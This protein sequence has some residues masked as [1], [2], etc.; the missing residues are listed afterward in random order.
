MLLSADDLQA[1][2]LSLKLAGLVTACLLVAGTPV[3]LWLARTGSRWK[4]L[5]GAVVAMPLVLPPT[6]L[7]FYLLL[8]M[9]PDGPVGKL[10]EA[11]GLDPLPFSFAGLV[12][13]SLVYSLPFAVQPIQDAFEAIGER[14]FEVASTLGASPIDA[15]F[16]VAIPLAKR[17][18]LSAAALTFAHT[19][20]EFGVVLML[21][22]KRPGVTRTASVEI[23][24]AVDAGEYVRAH[25]L[26][27]LLFAV[28]LVVLV[29]VRAWRPKT[30]VAT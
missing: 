30:R 5:V 3:A 17:G 14:P 16:T 29:A 22:G 21:G 27:G 12:V 18:F 13:G 10:T 24:D 28:A 4:G 15:F 2:L 23:F 8:A 20:G 11:L 25:R 1:F 9:G 7:G 26:A 19:M 6:V